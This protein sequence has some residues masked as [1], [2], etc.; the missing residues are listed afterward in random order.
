[1]TFTIVGFLTSLLEQFDKATH[2]RWSVPNGLFVSMSGHYRHGFL[3][4]AGSLLLSWLVSRR[5][6]VVARGELRGGTEFREATDR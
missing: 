2:L 3:R 6:C 5:S 1:M 4:V